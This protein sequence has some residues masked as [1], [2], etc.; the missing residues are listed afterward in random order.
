MKGAYRTKCHKLSKYYYDMD[1]KCRFMGLS[2]ERL[3]EKLH[4]FKKQLRKDNKE[5]KFKEDVTLQEGNLI[6]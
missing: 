1:R 6:K 2:R 5:G 3:S 4:S